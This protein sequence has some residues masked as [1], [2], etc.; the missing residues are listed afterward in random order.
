MVY[1]YT[2][3]GEWTNTRK[4]TNDMICITDDHKW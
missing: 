2:A 3:K 1:G 4:G